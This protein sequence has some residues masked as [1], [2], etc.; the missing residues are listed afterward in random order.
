MSPLSVQ[1]LE[2][3]IIGLPLSVQCSK[4]IP[5]GAATF[6]HDLLSYSAEHLLSGI[7]HIEDDIK[8]LNGGVV[9]RLA[10]DF[11]R[12]GYLSCY[13]AAL[14]LCRHT[15]IVFNHLEKRAALFYF[16]YERLL[17]H[18]RLLTHFNVYWSPAN[19]S[20]SGAHTDN[21]DVIVIQLSG[22]KHWKLAHEE[23]T[24]RSGDILFVRKGTL[25]DPVT[26]AINDSIH[27]TIGMVAEGAQLKYIPKPNVRDNKN[28][29]SDILRFIKS[30][31]VLFSHKH[32]TLQFPLEVG[33][34]VSC[35]D[36]VYYHDNGS[37]RF[38]RDVYSHVFACSPS[39]KQLNFRPEIDRAHVTNIILAFYKAGIPF[40]IEES[41]PDA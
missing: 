21:H 35:S 11:C 2:N 30:M 27:L 29:H 16:L 26:D 28:H 18:H 1:M 31:G 13:V 24:L 39:V 40:T 4:Y 25:H 32:M 37:L 15:T 19:C 23:V 9:T 17:D 8:L 7:Q 6:S 5:G 22:Q 10:P 14:L 41:V 38:G 36:I 12:D 33:R 20:G 3:I 34:K